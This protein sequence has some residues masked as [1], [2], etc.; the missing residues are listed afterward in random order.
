[1]EDADTLGRW[2]VVGSFYAGNLA[3]G[4]EPGD[5]VSAGSKE[6]NGQDDKNAEL[7][8]LARKM[9]MNTDQ[10]KK[11]FCT[12]MSADDYLDAY[13]KILKLGTKNQMERDVMFVLLDC[14]LQ[15][16]TFNPYYAHLGIKLSEVE[17]KYRLANQFCI[18]DKLKLTAEMK[19]FQ[20]INLGKY[21]SLIIRYKSQS[22]GVLRTIQFAEMN[23]TN[24]K[25]LRLILCDVLM[26][27]KEDEL[28]L[29]CQVV[30]KNQNWKMFSDGL[31]LFMQHFIIKKQKHLDPNIDFN[32]LQ[33]RVA[34]AETYLG[35]SK[36]KL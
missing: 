20:L 30:E 3:R 27:E 18:W 6:L 13:E 5:K 24:V 19:D 35:G 10:R 15:E 4:D 21:I 28:K 26:Q 36:L 33:K 34:L 25:L 23:K 7:P 1:L 22:I 16:K 2:W 9:R 17:R 29:I 11:I 32:K 14:S 31:K 8:E 12:V